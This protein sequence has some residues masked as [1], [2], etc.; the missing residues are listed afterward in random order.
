[1]LFHRISETD[2]AIVVKLANIGTMGNLL[3]KAIEL[4]GETGAMDRIIRFIQAGVLIKT[5]DGQDDEDD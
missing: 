1:V 3:E 4:G 2:F 5:R